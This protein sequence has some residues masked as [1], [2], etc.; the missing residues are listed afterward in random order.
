M[1]AFRIAP[2][3]ATELYEALS[4]PHCSPSTVSINGVVQY[5]LR[6]LTD[7]SST[8]MVVEENYVDADY[9]D[10]VSA[11]YVKCFAPYSSR[12]KRVH[13]FAGPLIGEATFR[14]S[15]IDGNVAPERFPAQYLGFVVAR[16]LPSAVVG[17]TV[18]ANYP[19][20]SGRRNYL[21]IRE[22]RAN[23]F[24]VSFSLQS[25]A[26]QQQD[27]ALAACATVALW[28]CFHQTAKLFNTTAPSP[29]TITRSAVKV[30]QS[31]PIPSKGLEIYQMCDAIREVHLEPEVYQPTQGLP[32]SSLIYSYLQLGQPVILGVEIEGNGLHAITVTGY[33]LRTTQV[34][35]HEAGFERS[36]AIQSIGSRIDELYAHDD[37]V[38]PFSRISIVDASALGEFIHLKGSWTCGSPARPAKLEIR[39]IIIPTY[40]KIRLGY[41]DIYAWVTKISFFLALTA[42]ENPEWDIYLTSSNKFKE[43]ARSLADTTIASKEEILFG[44]H[45]KYIWCAKLTDATGLI[46]EILFD[47][48]DIYGSLP[49]YKMVWGSLPIR[50]QLHS[51]LTVTSQD[52]INQALGERLAAFLLANTMPLP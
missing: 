1:S 45:P 36:L 44:S 27:R 46:L 29:A 34:I 41:A 48:T 42:L 5:L 39:S 25:L 52:I 40:H 43:R 14:A 38:G 26:F 32:I 4:N 49:A 7:V 15:V 35:K 6:Y 3:G 50:N 2:F 11:F 12:C 51:F 18:L 8:T 22:Y 10:D 37:Q 21:A 17:R 13:F 30:V 24:G 20:D 16:P 23:L 19:S 47:A 31:R 28:S 9:L 33:S